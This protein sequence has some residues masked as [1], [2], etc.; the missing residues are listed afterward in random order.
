M[1]AYLSEFRRSI[2]S[3]DEFWLDAA[4]AIDWSTMPTRALDDSNPPL[5]RWFPDG[6]LNTAFNALDR[7]ADGGR[8]DQPALIWDSAVTGAKRTYSYR[9]VAR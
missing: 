7:H 4:R 8:G 6:E 5:Y 1:G 3:R 2:E 9:R